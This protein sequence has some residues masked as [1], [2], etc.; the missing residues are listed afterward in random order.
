MWNLSSIAQFSLLLSL[1]IHCDA[2]QIDLFFLCHYLFTITQWKPW[3]TKSIKKEGE[4]RGSGMYK[5]IL[6]LHSVP[7]PTH[8]LILFH[9]LLILSKRREWWAGKVGYYV[10]LSILSLVPAINAHTFTHIISAFK[11]SMSNISLC[12]EINNKNKIKKTLLQVCF[13]IYSMQYIW[14]FS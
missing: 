13:Y 6:S 12:N 4:I 1:F 2:S 10:N 11:I 3:I 8:Y 7:S 5:H 14:L 9:I